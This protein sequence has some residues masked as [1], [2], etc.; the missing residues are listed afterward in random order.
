MR[1]TI[2][3]NLYSGNISIGTDIQLVQQ[4]VSG[5]ANAMTCSPSGG[6]SGANGYN[7][8]WPQN[9]SVKV[10]AT[11]V[12][13][14][15]QSG[16]VPVFNVGAGS[17]DYPSGIGMFQFWLGDP[18]AYPFVDAGE[19]KAVFPPSLGEWLNFEMMVPRKLGG[20]QDLFCVKYTPNQYFRLKTDL[21]DPV[22]DGRNCFINA[23]YL[24]E[25]YQPVQWS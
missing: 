16:L 22:L 12:Y 9:S 20:L 18:S 25:S 8:Y 23:E 4:T 17:S 1:W 24:V 3:H 21:L 10:L 13:S 11:R 5:Q 6:Q 15:L 7:F 2:R 14:N 19:P